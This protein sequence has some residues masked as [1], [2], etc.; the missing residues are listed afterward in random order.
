M[1]KQR[2]FVG[3]TQVSQERWDQIFGRKNVAKDKDGISIGGGSSQTQVTETPQGIGFSGKW[4]SMLL[5]W[6]WIIWGV[7]S[8]VSLFKKKA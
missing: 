4:G 7:T 6:N 5:P 8:V 1:M 2:P 3:Q